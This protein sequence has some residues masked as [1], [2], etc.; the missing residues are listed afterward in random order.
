[1]TNDPFAL[2]RVP[3]KTKIIVDRVYLSPKGR[4][5][6][7]FRV[8][9][10]GVVNCADM[11]TSQWVQITVYDFLCGDVPAYTLQTRWQVAVALWQNFWRYWWKQ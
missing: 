3:P 11:F 4:Y 10:T 2:D 5:L 1:M 9:V 6:K 8:S 7:V